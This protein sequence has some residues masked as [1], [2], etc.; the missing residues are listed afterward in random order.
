MSYSRLIPQFYYESYFELLLY[1]MPCQ[2][3]LGLIP[4][5]Y[6]SCSFDRD[7][8]H[9]LGVNALSGLY[10]ISTE[11][12][13]VVPCEMIASV[14]AL[15]GLYLISTGYFGPCIEF[16]VTCVNALSGLYL[17]STRELG[18]EE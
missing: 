7:F 1:G 16:G 15:S 9:L 8:K 6:S 3:P 11:P 5:F 18:E 14:N 13:F 17:I 10:L 2:C 4:H 12:D